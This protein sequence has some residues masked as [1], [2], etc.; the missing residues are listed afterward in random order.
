MLSA[1]IRDELQAVAQRRKYSEE[2]ISI[3]QL[4]DSFIETDKNEVNR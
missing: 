3:D 4:S 2:K 1:T